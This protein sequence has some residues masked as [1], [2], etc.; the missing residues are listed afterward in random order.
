MKKAIILPVLASAMLSGCGGGSDSNSDS[1]PSTKYE[2]QFV[3]LAER[4]IGAGP[5]NCT[6][7]DID[8]HADGKEI[9]AKLAHDVTVKTYDTNGNVTGDLSDKVNAETGVL[10]ITGNDIED[11]GY[12]SVINSPSDSSMLYD[13]LSIQKELLS[14]LVIEV[15]RHQG[16]VSCYTANKS[17]ALNTGYA[18]VHPNATAVNAY[19]FSSSQSEL[20]ADIPASKEVSAF[21]NEDV[22]VRAYNSDV[23]VDY[24]FVQ[25]LT[26]GAY[27]ELTALSSEA[28]SHYNWSIDQALTG[29]VLGL[30]VRLN[31]GDY[32]YPWLDA[33][34][35]IS[36]GVTTDFTHVAA[37]NSWSYRAEGKTNSGWDFKHNDTLSSSL[38]VQL[39]TEL[40]LSA[41]DPSI[42][43]VA[44]NFKFQAPGIDSTLARLQRS[45]YYI[46][47]TD[48]DGKTNT[49]NHVIYSSVASGD[50]VIIPNLELAN[51][52]DPEL[53]AI[54]LT[55]AVLSA[56]TLNTEL[57]KLFMHENAVS[58]LVSVVLTPADTV[59]NNKTRNTDTYTLLNR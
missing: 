13:V 52:D 47:V 32:S 3:Q 35:D 55:V 20:A 46:D 43:Y 14:D 4:N 56:D 48:T 42:S 59:K 19:A 58:D 23:L 17:A 33:V 11:G 31:R 16:N 9:Y 1:T 21:N 6:L 53:D 40:T 7:F 10:N 51:L 26:L 44:S 24:T 38:N 8:G 54:N 39:P 41:N 5:T 29:Q 18:S 27:D 50:D 22:L 15:D 45:S 34:F 25:K 57:T 30:S 49:L 37:E 36:S 12:V 2:L 28:F